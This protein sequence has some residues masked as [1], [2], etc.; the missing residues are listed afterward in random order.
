MTEKT[1]PAFFRLRFAAGLIAPLA[2]ILAAQSALAAQEASSPR[3]QAVAPVFPAAEARQ[4]LEPDSSWTPASSR[5]F[6][7]QAVVK[8]AFRQPSPARSYGA[9]VRFSPGARTYWHVHPLGQTLL[10]V[11]GIGLTQARGPDG[12]PSPVV[13][14]KAGDVVICPPGVMHWHGAS[15]DSPMTHL[16]I[17]ESDPARPVAWKD[18]VDD[19]S[20]LKGASKALKGR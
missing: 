1:L 9:Y 18:P 4:A 14:V 8:P 10:I 12:S 6:T 11:D 5:S 3:G 17:S 15:P 19:E 20:Y 16:A 13:A 7:G 2:A